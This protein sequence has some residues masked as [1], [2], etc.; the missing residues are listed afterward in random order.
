M[1]KR[2]IINEAEAILDHGL[3]SVVAPGDKTIAVLA[4]RGADHVEISAPNGF[5][6]RRS[7]AGGRIVITIEAKPTAS[8]V[9]LAEA[10]GA[11]RAALNALKAAEAATG[12]EVQ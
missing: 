2:D 9:A 6:V 4:H 11:L 12:R 7:E 10:R 5:N 3:I 8:E 1:S